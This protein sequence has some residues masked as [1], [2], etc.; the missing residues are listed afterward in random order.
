M[1]ERPSGSVP[2]QKRQPSGTEVFIIDESAAG[3]AFDA[4]IVGDASGADDTD[5]AEGAA[6]AAGDTTGNV[7]LTGPGVLIAA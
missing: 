6:V 7:A 1:T 4:S 5:G 3:A 2:P